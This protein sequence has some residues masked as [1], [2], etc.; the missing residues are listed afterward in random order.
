MK[1]FF[2]ILMG[3]SLHACASSQPATTAPG[4][5]QPQSDANAHAFGLRPL[6]A[7]TWEILSNGRITNLRDILL[8]SGKKS[9]IFQFAGVTCLTCQHDAEEYTRRI[10]GS[11]LKDKIT[12]VA[13]F[14]DFP[15][16]FQ[17]SDFST[18]M[19]KFAPQSLRTQDD[20][21]RLW[22]SLQKNQAAPD[23][24]VIIVLGQSGQGLSL[25]EATSHDI[26][27]GAL[28]TL[29]SGAQ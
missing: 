14:T 7:S 19:T 6:P 27:F 13:V 3:L 4:T 23:R 17:E 10:Q 25:N 12:H 22:L 15:E 16:D 21:A 9:A 8:A 11:S 2:A 18:F 28:E 1:F 5:R 20:H 29:A 26:I 24:N